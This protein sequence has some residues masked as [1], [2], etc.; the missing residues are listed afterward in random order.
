MSTFSSDE[1]VL[2][3]AIGMFAK[4]AN[5]ANFAKFAKFA[6]DVNRPTVGSQ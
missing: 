3:P 2:F 5:F 4:F 1:L 6:W